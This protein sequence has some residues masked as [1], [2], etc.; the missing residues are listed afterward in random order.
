MGGVAQRA[1]FYDVLRGLLVA[2]FRDGRSIAYSGPR[3]SKEYFMGAVRGHLLRR[4]DCLGVH[5]E[6]RENACLIGGEG[7]RFSPDPCA[8]L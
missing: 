6:R 3:V 1:I 7:S 8:F 2:L 4:E 5:V